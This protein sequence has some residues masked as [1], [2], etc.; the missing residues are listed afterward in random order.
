MALLN[1]LDNLRVASADE[2]QATE[3]GCGPGV[4]SGT[5][6]G[7]SDDL[8]DVASEFARRWPESKYTAK[9][10]ER[11]IQRAKERE[12]EANEARRRVYVENLWYDVK[13]QGNQL[14]SLRYRLKW[15]QENGP[16]TTRNAR[17]IENMKA[18]IGLEQNRFCE[19]KKELLNV[20]TAAEY[21]KLAKVHCDN[22]APVEDL[23]TGE[24]DLTA[25]CR[26]HFN[27]GC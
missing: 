27:G 13:M 2:Q 11:V 6:K 4:A 17:G 25:Q 7:N 5:L 14:V 18:G 8:D 22:D 23:G 16:K 10:G 1:L 19:A 9:L 20:T 12:A 15:L 26:A 21:R 24:V 3:E